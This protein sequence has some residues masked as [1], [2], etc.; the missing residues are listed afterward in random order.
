[1]Q[2]P[3]MFYGAPPHIFKKARELR[4][5]MTTSETVLWERLK[6]RQLNGY[7]FRRQHPIA[8]FI[9]DFYCHSAKLVIEVDGGIHE[10]K[11]RKEYDIQRTGE[12]NKLGVTVIR[13][14]NEE[15]ANSID[16]VLAKI[17]LFLDG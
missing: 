6:K 7:K 14:T 3:P 12:L 5:S 15:V 10:T 8:E 9:A 4:S 11:E 13:F 16:R 1:M 2:K 17:E